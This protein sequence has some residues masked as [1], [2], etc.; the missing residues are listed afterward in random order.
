MYAEVYDSQVKDSKDYQTLLKTFWEKAAGYTSV[1]VIVDPEQVPASEVVTFLDTLD[2]HKLP[3][4]HYT[5]NQQLHIV[6][7]ELANPQHQHA[8]E[9]LLAAQAH[10]TYSDNSNN[11]MPRSACLWL[12]DCALTQT[13]LEKLYKLGRV[14]GYNTRKLRFFRYWDPRV[15]VTLPY[16]LGYEQQ[17][18]LEGLLGDCLY[19]NWLGELTWLDYRYKY[20]AQHHELIPTT[21]HFSFSEKQW[22]WL[23]CVALINAVKRLVAGYYR[24]ED[25]VLIPHALK[26]MDVCQSLGYVSEADVQLFLTKAVT[27]GWQFY[28]HPLVA[29]HLVNTQASKTEPSKNLKQCLRAVT[30]EHWETVKRDI[31]QN[32]AARCSDISPNTDITLTMIQIEQ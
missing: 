8:I 1:S 5:L 30:P 14:Y 18:Q 31:K 29:N 24:I 17:I 11:V 13:K 32:I 25:E 6:Q 7:L 28:K 22:Q 27:V 16:I 12:F 23:N 2:A 9:N 19:L 26:S 4:M 3:Q 15:L 10:E 21:G 20:Y